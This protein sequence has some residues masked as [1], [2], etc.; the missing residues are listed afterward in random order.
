MTDHLNIVE[1]EYAILNDHNLTFYNGCLC[2]LFFKVQS[3]NLLS[4]TQ[5]KGIL[6]RQLLKH[7]F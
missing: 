3:Q 1:E 2:E 6:D 5:L 7:Y 4:K